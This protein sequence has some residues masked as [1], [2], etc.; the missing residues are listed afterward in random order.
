MVAIRY[1]IETLADGP[2]HAAAAKSSPVTTG[3]PEPVR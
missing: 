3:E 2:V 1:R